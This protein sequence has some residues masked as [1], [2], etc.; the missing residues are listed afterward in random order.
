MAPT[1][2][3]EPETGLT[4]LASLVAAEQVPPQ[5]PHSVSLDPNRMLAFMD[6]MEHAEKGNSVDELQERYEAALAHATSLGEVRVRIFSTPEQA[7]QYEIEHAAD[8]ATRVGIFGQSHEGPYP[9]AVIESSD[10]MAELLFSSKNRL[11]SRFTN[12]LASKLGDKMRYWKDPRS[13]LHT[14]AYVEEC[15]IER[16]ITV[17]DSNKKGYGIAYMDI[18]GFKR[19][20]DID[21]SHEMG[22]NVIRM[23]GE[24][25]RK[26]IRAEDIAVREGTSADEFMIYVFGCGPEELIGVADRIRE[27]LG[28]YEIP[29]HPNLKITAS[30]GVSHSSEATGAVG[31][32]AKLRTLK[33]LADRRMYQAKSDG[34]DRVAPTTYT[35]PAEGSYQPAASYLSA[36]SASPFPVE[37]AGSSKRVA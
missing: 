3:A 10:P 35:L 28:E 32:S 21:E 14:D 18:D 34:R 6:A 27:S 37:G 30:I 33:S 5:S 23:A 13:G 19:Y 29:G 17:G 24:A 4:G 9:I 25:I 20:N 16:R 8:N 7:E 26:N 1:C 36:S 2:V 11:F 31:A 12:G 15:G 22:N